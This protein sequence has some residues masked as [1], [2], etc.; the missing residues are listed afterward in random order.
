MDEK[1]YQEL[2]DAVF[3][4]I[5]DAFEDVDAEVVDCDHAGDVLTLAFSN[6]RRCVV[7]TQRPARQMWVAAN[8]RGW[9]FSYDES[10]GEWLDDKTH[11]DEL[12]TTLERIV[13]DG[14]QLDVA[15]APKRAD[16]GRP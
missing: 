6:G 4:R 13:R 2:A 3:R 15:I 7:N 5:V 16:R 12:F 9:H 11:A 10:C 1:R 14:A 8:A